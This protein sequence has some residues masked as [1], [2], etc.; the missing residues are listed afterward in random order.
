M[1]NNIKKRMFKYVKINLLHRNEDDIINQVYFNLKN[2]IKRTQNVC[3]ATSHMLRGRKLAVT[4]NSFHIHYLIQPGNLPLISS[5]RIFLWWKPG[6]RDYVTCPRSPSL[7]KSVS[8]GLD[9]GPGN[10][11]VILPPC[12]Q[13]L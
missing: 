11:E 13:A 4:G 9:P 5:A 12:E 10:S 7:F 6:L 1:G 8:W 2:S 3:E